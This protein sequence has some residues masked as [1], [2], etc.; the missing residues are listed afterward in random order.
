MREVKEILT[1]INEENLEKQFKNVKY[2]FKTN[3]EKSKGLFIFSSNIFEEEVY[4]ELYDKV[5]ENFSKTTYRNIVFSIPDLSKKTAILLIRKMVKNFNSEIKIREEKEE[6]V[7]NID[8]IYYSDHANVMRFLNYI[9]TIYPYF[10]IEES[11]NSVYNSKFVKE[12]EETKTNKKSEYVKKA[13]K[14]KVRYMSLEDLPKNG[15]S[16]NEFPYKHVIVKGKLIDSEM[17]AIKNGFIYKL[18][19]TDYKESLIINLFTKEEV[20]FNV[21]DE[22]N[23]E[24]VLMEDTFK[25]DGSIVLHV[26]SKDD[27][28]S[29]GTSSLEEFELE[30]SVNEKK[31]GIVSL[32]S[33]MSEY[34]G[35]NEIEDYLK[36]SE[37]YGIDT[38]T[39]CDYMGCQNFPALYKNASKYNVKGQYGIKF[40]VICGNENLIY[41]GEDNKTIDDIVLVDIETT[42]INVL[43]NDI[44]EL[45]AVKKVNGEFVKF[46]RLIKTKQKLTD[47]IIS[48]TNIDDE[49]LENE[50][51]SITEALKD[52][53]EFV[54]ESVIVGHNVSFD[55]AHIEES[56][57]KYLKTDIK[58]N[59]IDT[60]ILARNSGLVSRSYNLDALTVKLGLQDFNHHRATDDAMQT[61]YVFEKL[62]ELAYTNQT[63]IENLKENKTY[64]ITFSALGKAKLEELDN[65]LAENNI[66]FKKTSTSESGK[67]FSYK[68]ICS[69]ENNNL[70]ALLEKLE[71]IKVKKLEILENN[72]DYN[73]NCQ[74]LNELVN[75]ENIDIRKG[76]KMNI[77]AKNQDGLKALYKL[78][79]KALTTNLTKHG[80]FITLDDIAQYRANLVVNSGDLLLKYL[81]VGKTD[82]V[83]DYI[84][85]S[86]YIEIYSF[87]YYKAF[88]AYYEIDKAQKTLS[89]FIE[90]NI[91]KA[92]Y[93]D[94]VKYLYEN[95]KK[96][97]EIVVN[98]L[99]VGGK[100]HELFEKEVPNLYLKTTDTI[101]NELLKNYYLDDDMLFKL[102]FE[103]NEKFNQ[104]ISEIEVIPKELFAPTDDFLKDR[105]DVTGGKNIE[106]VEK[107]FV[108]LLNERIKE[109]EFK[110]EIHPRILERFNKE[111]NSIIKYKFYIMYYIAYMLVKKSNEDGYVVGSR[112]SVG[113]S[114][115]AYLMNITEVN[116][117]EPHYHCNICKY[118]A[119]SGDDSK[120]EKRL[121]N[122]DDGF[123][124]EDAICPVCG[125]KLI[126]DGHD[127]P[128]ETFLGFEGDK[129]PDIDLNFSGEYQGKAHDYTKLLFGDDY[130]F[131]AGTVGTVAFKTAEKMIS[132][133][134]NK[135]GK[136]VSM[137]EIE[138]EAKNI[139]GVKRTTGQ[140]PGG[141]I[142]VPKT[143]EIYDFTPIQYPSNKVQE[144]YT[145]HLDYHSIDA[146]LLKLDILGHDDPT[147]L[148]FLMDLVKE[149]PVLSRKIKSYKDIPVFDKKTL[150]LLN[151]DESGIINSLGISEFGT[152]FVKGMLKDIK[153][154]TF[155]DLI[156]TSGLSH[157]TNVWEDN[158]SSLIKGETPFGEIAFKD[159]IGCRDDVMRYLINY[160]LEPKLAFEIMEFVRK[161]KTYKDKE[162][163]QKYKEEMILHNVPNF[164]IYS[165]EK[166]MYL[167]PKAHAT[168][169]VMSAMRIAWFKAHY[170]IMFYCAYFS[171]RSSKVNAKLV[172]ENNIFK[173]EEEIKRINEMKNATA[174]DKDEKLFLDVARECIKK[175]ITFKAPDV[176][177]SHYKNY[178]ADTNKIL[179]PLT[180][181][182]GVGEK[183]AYNV[184]NNRKDGYNSLEELKERGKANKKFIEN[185]TFFE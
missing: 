106:S 90:T 13:F 177:K 21:G 145:T 172:C 111:M 174:T 68:F 61:Y 122:V 179:F 99:L 72:I 74:K 49:L 34:D 87:D 14:T 185:L 5:L 118:T 27:I 114:F 103:N 58:F 134:Y 181:I 82:N 24:G 146:N 44:I 105:L 45:G 39:L 171:I 55:I 169:Y 153:P 33:K 22:L 17:K 156:K 151:E 180:A 91:N 175:G 19:I 53:L 36:L 86:D 1:K 12:D 48:L 166:I 54:G 16:L 3:P 64:T 154:K 168:A 144:W 97:Y 83:K 63:D 89:E 130:T 109:Y 124:L 46:N 133:Y 60:M 50:G 57:R 11:K 120:L 28:E 4:L 104:S 66:D 38:L 81:E 132:D 67:N 32:Q 110:G 123:D 69:N 131:R 98:T 117:L 62:I 127:I 163:W 35:L 121:E 183:M 115:V 30:T 71:L 119:F 137:A 142:V 125:E 178:L 10:V 138:R 51:V 9:L 184:Y 25:N 80:G 152:D 47:E 129:T 20:K 40:N 76:I 92:L 141:I 85:I 94:N 176:N 108:S 112:G 84:D 37:T 135:I 155:S 100:K 157:G 150:A 75:N 96:Y 42:G 78:I 41:K 143:K 31:R 147:M 95:Q 139:E 167:F 182:E 136:L 162:K 93:S 102:V 113:S 161:G 158:A 140:H 165:A 15:L 70:K 128:F 29:F 7:V 148:K 8:N 6:L 173:I 52:F 149:D 26:K 164:F 160:G 126:K 73:M 170:P 77:I 107:E 18:L 56:I 79:S 116:P 65:L 23:V 159:V 2:E 88:L 101:K 59:T 43:T